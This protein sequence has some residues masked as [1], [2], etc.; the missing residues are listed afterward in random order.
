MYI[1]TAKIEHIKKNA[2]T[3]SGRSGVPEGGASRGVLFPRTAAAAQRVDHDG[4][5]RDGQN[6]IQENHF[7][8]PA[9]AG[10]FEAASAIEAPT[11]A[12]LATHSSASFG[13]RTGGAPSF[14][15]TST[16]SAI[17]AIMANCP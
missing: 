9:A 6:D 4:D 14:F 12:R 8:F 7:Y 3:V 16:D 5:N 11:F 10:S 1:K 17:V 15:S 2:E 13:S